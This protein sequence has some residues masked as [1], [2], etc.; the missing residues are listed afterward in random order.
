M[1]SELVLHEATFRLFGSPCRI[2]SD[3]EPSVVAAIHRLEDLHARWSRFEPDSEV[4]A[5]NRSTGFTSVSDVTLLLVERACEASRR[6]AGRMNP[7]LLDSLIALGYDRSHELLEPTDGD[8]P[9]NRGV[10]NGESETR[11]HRG[12]IEFDGSAVCLPEGSSFDPGGIGKGLAA[13]LAMEG[14]VDTG[15]TWALVSLGGDMRFGGDRLAETGWTT[16]IENPHDRR[17]VVASVSMSTGAIASSSRLSRRWSH[18][19]RTHHHLLDPDTGAPARSTRVAATVHADEAWWADVVAKVLVIDD[20]VGPAELDEWSASA[21][22][23]DVDGR[24]EDLGLQ[25]QRLDELV[26]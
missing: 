17:R 5:L 23:F 24:V 19:G 20:L 1:A 4:S 9:R 26:P 10:E 25:V 21:I 14:L 22:A 8:E 11:P 3:V 13:D 7:L 16:H 6:T 18:A 12:E 2:V 15:A